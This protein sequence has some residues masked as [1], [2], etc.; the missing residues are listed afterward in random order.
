[1]ANLAAT[2]ITV[3]VLN[4]RSTDHSRRSL[5]LQLTF[6]DGVKTYPAGGVP[7]DI[8]AF[9]CKNTIES[10]VI[11]DRDSSVYSWSYDATNAKLVALQTGAGLSGPLAQPSAVAIAAQSLKC[12]VTGW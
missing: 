3:T 12:E 1:M 7:I 11:Y 9:G 5:N 2:D 10:L 8:T 4:R 6:G